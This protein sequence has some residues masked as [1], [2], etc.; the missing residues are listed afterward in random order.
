MKLVRLLLL[1]MLL[2]VAALVWST[3]LFETAHADRIYEGVSAFNVDLSGLTRDDA[4]AALRSRLNPTQRVYLRDGT[5][6]FSLSLSELGITLDDNTVL[7]AAFGIGRVCASDGICE[8]A[9]PNARCTQTFP[10]DLLTRPESYPNILVYG[11]LVVNG[12]ES[13]R[14]RG[15]AT[16][17]AATQINEQG[18]LDG[19]LFGIV[20]CDV[21]EDPK[22]DSLKRTD[23]V[24][25][26]I[27]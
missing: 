7:N 3:A 27:G 24:I 13:Q 16:R 12:I 21:N 17:L 4:R 22:Y 25:R 23:A 8:V 26:H 14:A 18:G 19:R 1:L 20:F 11:S 15:N 10:A 2:G 6:R 5:Q 9:P